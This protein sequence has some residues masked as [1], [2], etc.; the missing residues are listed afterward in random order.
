MEA[1][2]RAENLAGQDRDVAV[3]SVRS[4]A[5]GFSSSASL[6]EEVGEEIDAILDE[7]N[8]FDIS[9]KEFGELQEA[10]IRLVARINKYNAGASHRI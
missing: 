7:E 3:K 4:D 2:N 6:Q 5:T 10:F 1:G 9:R 8:T